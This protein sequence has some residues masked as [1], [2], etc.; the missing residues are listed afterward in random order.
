[1]AF[2]INVQPGKHGFA[3]EVDETVLDAALRQGVILP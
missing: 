2:K 3:A 1:M